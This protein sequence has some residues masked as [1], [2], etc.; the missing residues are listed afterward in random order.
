MKWTRLRHDSF[1]F[2]TSSGVLGGG[3]DAGGL[4]G[5]VDQDLFFLLE[6]LG[7]NNN[8]RLGLKT[9]EGDRRGREGSG[10][11]SIVSLDIE[12]DQSPLHV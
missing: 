1:R 8:V 9:D 11:G 12:E 7:L 3:D 2:E 4:P 10:G 5:G 6:V